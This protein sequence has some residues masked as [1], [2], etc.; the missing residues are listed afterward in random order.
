MIRPRRA[1]ACTVPM[2]D[3]VESK[4]SPEMFS[5]SAMMVNSPNRSAKL[6]RKKKER[7]KR[8]ENDHFR[9]E[10]SGSHTAQC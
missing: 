3:D 8:L 4:K 9:R 6:A 2:R 5:P 1:M 10:S 7:K